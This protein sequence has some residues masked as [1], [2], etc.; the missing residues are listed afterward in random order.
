M[1]NLHTAKEMFPQL[2]LISWRTDISNNYCYPTGKTDVN[3][4]KCLPG[5][6]QFITKVMIPLHFYFALRYTKQLQM[7][8]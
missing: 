6:L 5:S 3:R 1:A 8:P 2:S 7:T 4:L